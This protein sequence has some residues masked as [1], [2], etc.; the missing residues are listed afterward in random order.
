MVVLTTA[1]TMHHYTV[2]MHES[3][4]VSWDYYRPTLRGWKDDQTQRLIVCLWPFM[5]M[6]HWSAT[7]CQF[8]CVL[9]T[10]ATV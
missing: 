10:I 2:I 8:L 3:M 5:S 4:A 9:Q 1:R 6:I 7:S